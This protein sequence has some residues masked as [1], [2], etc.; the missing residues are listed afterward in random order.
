MYQ[1]YMS[2]KG[3]SM[4]PGGNTLFNRIRTA[5]ILV[6][7]AAVILLA[8]F[9]GRAMSFEAET[10]STFVHRMQTEC[11][12]ALSLTTALSRT[13]GASSSATLGKIRSHVYAMDT[14]NQLNVGLGGNYLISNDTFTSLYAIIDDYSNRLI[15]GM[16]TGDSQTALANALTSLQ[17]TV[18]YLE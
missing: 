6:L 10:R 15:T 17:E 13:A 2:R 12:D 18:A 7:L 16:V 9:G 1:H 14:I 5:L 8:I 11:N 3:S 4:Q